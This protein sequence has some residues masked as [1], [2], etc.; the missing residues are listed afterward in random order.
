MPEVPLLV[1]D[2]ARKYLSGDEDN[3]AVVSEFFEAIEQF[4]HE[5]NTAVI[6]V[7]H[8]SKGARP[9]SAHEVLDE[10]RGSQ[11]FIDRPRVVIGMFREG[12]KTVIGLAKCNI[13]P[14]LGMVVEERVFMR[15]AKTLTLHQLPGAEGV[16]D[17]FAMPAEDE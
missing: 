3:S 1:I 11:V 6:V 13:P 8:L 16:R 14:S 10:L 7:H 5:R 17:P 4:A 12:P 9:Q 2:P 15:D